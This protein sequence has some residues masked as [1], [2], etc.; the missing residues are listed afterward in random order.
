MRRPAL[1]SSLA[2]LLGPL[3][4]ACSS[5][6]GTQPSNHGGVSLGGEGYVDAAAPDG[7]KPMKD[8]GFVGADGSVVRADR[9]ATTVV[10]FAPGPCAGFGIPGMPKVIQGPPVGAGDTLGGMDVV[11]LGTKGEIV[12]SFGE[13]AIVD[14]PGPDF[15][16]FENPFFAAGDP[17]KPNAELA[18]VS[19]SEDGMTWTPFPCALASAPPYGTCAGWRPVYSAPGNGISPFDP[20]SAGG[21]AFDLADVGVPSARFVRIRDLGATACDAQTK[22]TNTGFDLDAVAIIHAQTP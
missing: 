6:E 7:E 10:S 15:I 13:N 21:D 11:S 8:G 3:F 19:V 4:A 1:V 2:S 5:S 14:A 9:F 12:L 17:Q 16:V 20:G 22:P 18:E